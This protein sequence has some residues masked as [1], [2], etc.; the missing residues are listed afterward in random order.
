MT[1]VLLERLTGQTS[2][3]ARYRVFIVV[4]SQRLTNGVLLRVVNDGKNNLPSEAW[5]Y[6]PSSAENERQ[7]TLPSICRRRGIGFC[8]STSLPAP[9][10]SHSDQNLQRVL[11]EW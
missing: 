10:V 2:D 9:L 5:F 1:D 4:G 3:R 6:L 11:L 8:C 7:R